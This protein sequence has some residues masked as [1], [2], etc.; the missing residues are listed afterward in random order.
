[1]KMFLNKA[2]VGIV[3]LIVPYCIV[4]SIYSEKI[5][6]VFYRGQYNGYGV[7][8][9]LIGIKYVIES[10]HRTNVIGLRVLHKPQKV[11][12][13]YLFTSILTICVSIPLVKFFGVR[14][15][16]LGT[17]LSASFALYILRKNFNKT[18]VN[19]RNTNDGHTF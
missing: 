13:A 17:I 1:M 16:A 18:I 15:A 8:V 12:H 19:F 5:L 6:S 9:V 14:G 4:V 11:F 10:M 2:M 7:I 3:V